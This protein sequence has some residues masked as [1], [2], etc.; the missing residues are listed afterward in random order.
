MFILRSAV[1]YDNFFEGCMQKNKCKIGGFV[2]ENRGS[3]KD[4]YSVTAVVKINLEI[5]KMLHFDSDYMEGMHPK[6]LQRLV[7]TNEE[8][9]A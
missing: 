2:G 7:E 6:I 8:Q 9:T 4:C 1:I 3:T 5:N